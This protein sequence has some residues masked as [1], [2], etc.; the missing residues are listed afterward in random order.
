MK[1]ELTT[2]ES[3]ECVEKLICLTRQHRTVCGNSIGTLGVHR[4]QHVILMHLAS[5][6]EIPSQKEL[7]KAFGVSPA[8][9]VT[10]LQKLEKA[11]YITRSASTDDR[12]NNEIR[13]TEEG[14]RVVLESRR[15]F[16]GIDRI[17]MRGVTEE[18]AE[19][20][21]RITDKLSQNL[22]DI[23]AGTLDPKEYG[24]TDAGGTLT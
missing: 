23:E 13:I 12:R 5:T 14:R 19:M 9:I 24:I 11:G 3:R 16:S 18:E 10:H 4:S 15:I 21:R 20:L 8:A 7:A 22:S 17:M 1:E 6:D 2:E